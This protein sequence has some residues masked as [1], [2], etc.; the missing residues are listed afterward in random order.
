MLARDFAGVLFDLDGVIL[1]SMQQHARTWQEVFREMGLEVPLGFILEN[2]GSLGAEVLEDYLA[3]HAPHLAGRPLAETR[4]AMRDLLDRQLSLYLEQHAHQVRPYAGAARLLAGLRRAGLPVALV[5]SSRRVLVQRSLGP[6]LSAH[7]QAL[8]C[9]EDVT[10][11]KPHP[12]PYQAGAKALDLAAERCL[13]V[14]NAP[15]GIA[16]A[17]AAGATC[18]ALTT[19]LAAP[20]L[21]QAQAVFNGL[22]DLGR[23]L[24]VWE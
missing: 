6:E 5:T 1:D 7:F 11:H 15:A 13:V 24:G 20:K 9:A 8:V 22:E 23:H 21:A 14:E 10:R 12:D 4:R 3:A 18:Y 2:E 17:R 19:T 16:S